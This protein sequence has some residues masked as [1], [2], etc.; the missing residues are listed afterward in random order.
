MKSDRTASVR[1]FVGAVLV[2]VSNSILRMFQRWERRSSPVADLLPGV[3]APVRPLPRPPD[4]EMPPDEVAS[5]ARTVSDGAGGRH[6]ALPVEGRGPVRTHPCRPRP[7]QT[8]R[9]H[10]G[11]RGTGESVAAGV[12]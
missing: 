10:F 1:S 12:R 5:R 6:G 9:A 11:P 7:L 8:S 4:A 3:P 2:S